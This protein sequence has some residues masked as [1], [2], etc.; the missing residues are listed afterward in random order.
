MNFLRACQAP[1]GGFGGGPS[2]LP[3]LAPTYAAVSTLVTIGEEAALSSIDSMALLAFVRRMCVPIGAGGGIAVS[4]GAYTPTFPPQKLPSNAGA[5]MGQLVTGDRC[6]AS[7]KTDIS[8]IG[9]ACRWRGGL[10]GL[11]HR[12][13]LTAHAQPGQERGSRALRHSRLH[14]PVS[15][16]TL[17][18]S[19]DSAS[20]LVSAATSSC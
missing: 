20:I 19:T 10:Q 14:F 5:C 11:L 13:S 7:K 1:T 15:G 6:Q 16:V 12:H 4:E 17:V 3:H 9:C 8:T 18:L 2:Q